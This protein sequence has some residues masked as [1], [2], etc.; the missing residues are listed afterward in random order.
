MAIARITSIKDRPRFG[1]ARIARRGLEADAGRDQGPEKTAV[2]SLSTPG[3]PNRTAAGCEIPLN[4]VD[5]ECEM[6]K[7]LRLLC[8]VLTYQ[9]TNH[10]HRSIGFFPAATQSRRN[11]LIRF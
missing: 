3:S 5:Y 1:R 10:A 9:V 6:F 2:P 8:H 4:R 11:M 7:S